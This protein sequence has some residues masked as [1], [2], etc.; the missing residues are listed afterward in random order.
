MPDELVAAADAAAGIAYYAAITT[1][2]AGEIRSRHDLWPTAAAAAGRL[3][4]GAVLLGASLKGDERVSLQIAGDGPLGT[5]AADSWLLPDGAIGARAYVGN[6]RVELPVNE[7][8]K[9]DVATAVGEGFLQV[10]RSRGAGQ[11]YVGIVSLRSG[12][13]AEDIALY[14][15]QSE[16]LPAVV[17]L[18][19]LADPG[20]IVAA[21]GILAHALPGA[22]ESALAALEARALALGPVTELVARH[23]SASAL[24]QAIAGDAPLRARR[25]VAVRFACRCN[26]QRVE[27][28]LAGL[29]GDD[30]I[31]LAR[32]RDTAEAICEYCKTRY[33]FTPPELR[34]IADR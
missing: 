18:G 20:G 10:T 24:L 25:G 21:G 28:L 7:R 17:A 19:V 4:T 6:P 15:A 30:L 31:A 26:R 12:E 27:T 1:G 14:L 34:A 9:F 5:V 16:Q 23:P 11:P 13:I 29:G 33:T 2:L 22:G 8:G 32:E 3:A